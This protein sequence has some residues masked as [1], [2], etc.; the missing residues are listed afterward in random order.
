MQ[1]PASEQAA[2][3]LNRL[4]LREVFKYS[5]ARFSLSNYP[6]PVALMP[7]PSIIWQRDRGQVLRSRY[8][9]AVTFQL[10]RTWVETLE[11]R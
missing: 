6:G 4:E 7:A 11:R 3:P 8:R 1:E 9:D 2:M 10:P 5:T